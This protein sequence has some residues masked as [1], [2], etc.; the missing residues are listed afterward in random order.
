M[1]TA[2][3]NFNNTH[4]RTYTHARAHTH[5]HTYT[6]THTHNTQS[7]LLV[8]FRNVCAMV[9]PRFHGTECTS[10]RTRNME[11]TK[12]RSRSKCP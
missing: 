7:A 1:L 10:S 3:T 11:L 5:A 8:R 6:H 9:F 2:P 12:L 4:A